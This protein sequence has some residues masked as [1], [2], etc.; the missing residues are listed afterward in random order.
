MTEVAS[1]IA[2]ATEAPKKSSLPTKLTTEEMNLRYQFIGKCV[3]KGIMLTNTTQLGVRGGQSIQDLCNSNVKTL[4]D[5]AIKMKK[6]DANHD[7]EFSS[8]E[9]LKFSGIAATEWLEFFRLTI[10]KKNW[11]VYSSDKREHVKELKERINQA[12]TPEELRREAQAELDGLKDF[13]K[14]D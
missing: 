13:D 14:E 10:R 6:E 12:K 4:Q 7:P 8:S 9:I 1:P 5:I 11:D 2:V 3:D